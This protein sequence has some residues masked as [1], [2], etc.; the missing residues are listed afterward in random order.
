ME[1]EVILAISMFLVAIGALLAGF[2]VAFTLGGVALVFA[3]IGI[4]LDVVYLSDLKNF[5]ARIDGIMRNGVLV[6]VPFFVIMGVVL[7]RSRVAEDLL[8]IA[9]RLLG[10]I[11]GGLGYAV[12]LVGALLA[13]STGIVGA[14]VIT[15]T[16]IALPTML[17][18]GYDPK[19]ATGI[20]ASS[21][22]LGQIIPPSIVLI[23]LADAIANASAQASTGLGGRAV[24]I[25]VQ[26][27]FSGAL[28]PGLLLVCLYL[29]YIAFNAITR[30]QSCPPA[31]VSDLPPLT[32]RQIAMGL[33]APIALIFAV[34]GSILLGIT[35]PT[36]AAAIGAGGAVLLAGF[37]LSED[38]PTKLRPLLFVGLASAALLLI[39]N[40]SFELSVKQDT[41]DKIAQF[42]AFACIGGLLAGLGA[43]LLILRR[44]RHLKSAFMSASHITS[45]VFTILIGASLF[46]LVFTGSFRGDEMIEGV[47]TAMPGGMWGALAITMLVMFVLGFFLD[48]IEIIFII[49]PLVAPPL[50]VLGV[51]P[52]WLAIL[53]A[54]NLQ[55]SFLTPP[56]GF[57]LF[58]LRGAAPDSV[59]TLDIWRGALPFI[60]LQIIM[61]IAVA[62]I[63]A[64]ATW[65]PSLGAS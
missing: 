50:I 34:L 42:I 53:M 22:T 6:A 55:T 51:D 17:K 8:A 65:L 59:Q 40:Q 36:E 61:I 44:A 5:P 63:P 26:D 29:A 3:L 7:E 46:S 24:S 48:F 56:F 60:G 9:S 11:R 64:L 20:I 57:A 38:T 49:V 58:Y 37:R 12:V 2:P 10:Q 35:P 18:Q 21:G 41:A 28:I 39:L 23:L 15:M 31:D 25:S 4:S 32:A 62:A 1:I 16:L 43:G 30:P 45:M 33:G 13:A 19:L 27:L 54:L 52:I 14:T 47:L